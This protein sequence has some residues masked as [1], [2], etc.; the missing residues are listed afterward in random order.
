M[1]GSIAS[2]SVGAIF[3]AVALG[4]EEDARRIH[5]RQQQGNITPAERK[6]YEDA[7]DRRNEFRV[8]S[9]GSLIAAGVSVITGVC[10]HELDSPNLRDAFTPAR[11]QAAGKMRLSLAPTSGGGMDATLRF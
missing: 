4:A 11:G 2:A 9:I 8:I 7:L 3:G 5:V 10:L 1:A 6:Q